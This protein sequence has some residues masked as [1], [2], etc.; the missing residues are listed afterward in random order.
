MSQW[1]FFIDRD[2]LRDMKKSIL[3]S[4]KAKMLSFFILPF[5]P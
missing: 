4:S 5:D 3:I 2:F 1:V